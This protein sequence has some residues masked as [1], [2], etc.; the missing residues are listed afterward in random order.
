MTLL[1]SGRNEGTEAQAM[2]VTTSATD[3]VAELTIWPGKSGRLVCWTWGREHVDV[4]LRSTPLRY[5][6]V[7]RRRMQD[8][9]ALW[10]S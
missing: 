1:K 9:H 4:L 2:P 7:V 6:S 3:Q 5:W 10:P 8:M